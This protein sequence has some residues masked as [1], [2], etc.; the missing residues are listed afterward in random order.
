MWGMSHPVTMNKGFK[1]GKLKHRN[2]HMREIKWAIKNYFWYIKG[3]LNI[4]P[5]GDSYT[6]A[7]NDLQ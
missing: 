7:N 2:K 5:L 1:I 3:N 4:R 6:P